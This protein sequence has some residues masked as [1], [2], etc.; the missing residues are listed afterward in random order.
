[1]T[2]WHETLRSVAFESLRLLISLGGDQLKGGNCRQASTESKACIGALED[3]LENRWRLAA[4]AEDLKGLELSLQTCRQDL[5][6]TSGER[7]SWIWLIGFGLWLLGICCGFLFGVAAREF[8]GRKKKD[9]KVIRGSPVPLS[10][11]EASL[12]TPKALKDGRHTGASTESEVARA[13]A[14]ARALQG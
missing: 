5:A 9:H 11:V 3:C 14:R 6:R 13:R 10:V 4:A 8:L 2:A 1:M 12:K 7:G